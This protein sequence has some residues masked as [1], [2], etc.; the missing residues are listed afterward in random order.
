M[1]T[2][3]RIELLAN[4]EHIGMDE[5]VVVTTILTEELH[6]NHVDYGYHFEIKFCNICNPE[7]YTNLVLPWTQSSDLRKIAQSISQAA[8]LLEKNEEQDKKTFE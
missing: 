1:E 2:S 8:D 6:E 4:E 7:L 5:T 3:Q